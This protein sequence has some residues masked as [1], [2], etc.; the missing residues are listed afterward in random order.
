LLHFGL[1]REDGLLVEK[2]S[3]NA[4]NGPHVDM[5]SVLLRT[6]QKLGRSIPQCDD[7]VGIARTVIGVLN[8]GTGETKIGKLED[9]L[10]VDEQV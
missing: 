8:D 9:A 1:S 2:L 5:R 4:A 7:I 3:E 10:I 6:K